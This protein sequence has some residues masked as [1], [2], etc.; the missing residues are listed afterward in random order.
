MTGRTEDIRSQ[1]NGLLKQAV[2][3]VEGMAGPLTRAVV[4]RLDLDPEKLVLQRNKWL[5]RLGAES[6]RWAEQDALP[7]PQVV[8]NALGHVHAVC[9]ALVDDG[10]HTSE[11]HAEAT[12][13]AATSAPRS[14]APKSRRKASDSGKTTGKRPPR[15]R[16]PKTS[17]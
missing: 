14:S 12:V 10:A 11:H 5:G 15:K 4:E 2:V 3:Q 13:E 7:L 9:D 8:K 16:S 6:A 17:H 1:V